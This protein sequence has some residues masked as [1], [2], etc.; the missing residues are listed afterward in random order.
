MPLL[1]IAGF[2]VLVAALMSPLA[3]PELAFLIAAVPILF[4]GIALA[5]QYVKWK[6]SISQYL[7]ELYYGGPFETPE[8][9]VNERMIHTFG[10]LDQAEVIRSIYIDE[11]QRCDRK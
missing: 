11:I 1:I 5:T 3:I 9:T 10:S 8:F 7:R 4:I 2:V 6:N